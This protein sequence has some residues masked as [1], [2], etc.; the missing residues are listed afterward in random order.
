MSV[1]KIKVPPQ[2]GFGDIDFLNT[3]T[4]SIWP[5]NFGTLESYIGIFNGIEVHRAVDEE[6]EK[7]IQTFKERSKHEVVVKFINRTL[8]SGLFSSPNF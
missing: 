4:I 6:R 1:L 2:Q 8:R 7:V 5:L 3:I